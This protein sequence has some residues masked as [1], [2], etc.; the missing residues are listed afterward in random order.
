MFTTF[1]LLSNSKLLCICIENLRLVKANVANIKGN[2]CMWTIFYSATF[3]YFGQEH[4]PY[5]M[6]ILSILV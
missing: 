4:Y 2:W 5:A 1:I 3:P 6:C